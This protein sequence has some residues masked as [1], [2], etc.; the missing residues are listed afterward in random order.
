MNPLRRRRDAADRLPPLECGH[1]DPLD[2]LVAMRTRST[3]LLTT[4]ELLRERRKL[5]GFGWSPGEIAMVLSIDP[6]R[7]DAS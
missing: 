5:I 3:Y 4:A 1:R 2:H 7:A 6:I